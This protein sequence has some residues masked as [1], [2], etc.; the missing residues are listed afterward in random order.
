MQDRNNRVRD[1]YS[2]FYEQ[3]YRPQ[4]KLITKKMGVDYSH[5]AKWRAGKLDLTDNTLNKVERF[6]EENLKG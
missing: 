4:M 5:F 3:Y 1:M 2:K 6:L